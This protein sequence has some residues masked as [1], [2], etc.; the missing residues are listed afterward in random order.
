MCG[1]TYTL[2]K[3]VER[4]AVFYTELLGIEVRSV[5]PYTVS[6][7]NVLSGRLLSRCGVPIEDRWCQYK[8]TLSLYTVQCTVK[9]IC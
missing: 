6:G 1:G 8:Y 3:L 4:K 5:L 7:A 9:E 2:W